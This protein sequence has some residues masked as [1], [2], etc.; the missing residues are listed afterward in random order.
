VEYTLKNLRLKEAQLSINP[1][2]NNENKIYCVICNSSYWCAFHLNIYD[3]E[4]QV[5]A[6]HA[7]NSYNTEIVPI[8]T[9]ESFRI[10]NDHMRGIEIEFL[11]NNS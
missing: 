11:K 2:E 4:S 1:I 8:E 9:G 7:C 10:E 6:C 3:L 5:I